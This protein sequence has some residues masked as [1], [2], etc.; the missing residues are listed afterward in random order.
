MPGFD[1]TSTLWNAHQSSCLESN[2][3][4]F[5][6]LLPQDPSMNHKA[7]RDAFKKMKPPKIPFMPLLLKGKRAARRQ[8]GHD[9]TGIRWFVSW[10]RNAVIS[11]GFQ[12]SPSSMKGTKHFMIIWWILRSWWVSVIER[13]Q[14]SL[15]R[16][17]ID[18][19]LCFQH[20]IA[21]TVRLIRHCQTDQTGQSFL[22][23]SVQSRSSFKNDESITWLIF[24]KVQFI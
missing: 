6:R 13:L 10:S 2:V 11:V 4:R 19:C 16:C 18:V 21:D 17:V 9:D 20:M 12:I 23:L 15:L 3:K 1:F 24:H 14:R 8:K 22:L 7:Y 5:I